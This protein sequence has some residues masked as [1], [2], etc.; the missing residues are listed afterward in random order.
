MHNQP[1]TFPRLCAIARGTLLHDPRVDYFEWSEKIKLRLAQLHL[2]SPTPQDMTAAQEAVER[3]L[4]KV[5][6]HRTPPP[7]YTTPP[8]PRDETRGPTH[9]EALR[10]LADLKARGLMPTIKPMPDARPPTRRRLEQRSALR[11][12]MALIRDQVQVCEDAEASVPHD[13]ATDRVH[14]DR[15][16][17]AARQR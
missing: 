12:V 6:I 16:A 10:A 2:D 1:L 11:Q 3:A 13:A 5:G 9:A 14:R 8:P 15:R 17:A 7:V 4:A